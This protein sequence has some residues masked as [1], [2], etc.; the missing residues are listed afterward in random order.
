M[1]KVDKV[2]NNNWIDFN[3]KIASLNL[4]QLKEAV[5]REKKGANRASFLLRLNK[6]IRALAGK[7]AIRGL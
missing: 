7:M 3:K 5:R 2:L 4:K 6:R 1:D